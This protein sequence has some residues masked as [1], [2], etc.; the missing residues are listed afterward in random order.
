MVGCVVYIDIRMA[1]NNFPLKPVG[2]RVGSQAAPAKEV[3]KETN[4][5]RPYDLLGAAF[6]GDEFD[7]VIFEEN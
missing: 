7:T 4:N 3:A 6:F 1:L 2:A 5:A